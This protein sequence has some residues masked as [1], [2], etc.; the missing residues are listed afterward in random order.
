MVVADG[1]VADGDGEVLDE[2]AFPVGGDPFE[3]TDGVLQLS[4]GA[5][6]D[7]GELI[8]SDSIDGTEVLEG[9][10]QTVGG[11][12]QEFVTCFMSEVVVDWLEA[13]HIA[14]HDDDILRI[15]IGSQLLE[16]F[17]EALAT[18]EAC[19]CVFVC[20]VVGD[21]TLLFELDLSLI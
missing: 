11:S 10:L 7:T 14:H 16:G 18:R 19:E 6:E 20:Q 21:V 3:L 1:G 13:I 2:V 15:S 5:M 8:A 17:V 4:V 9:F 12:L